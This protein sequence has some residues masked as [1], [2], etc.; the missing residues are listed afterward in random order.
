MTDVTK[1]IDIVGVNRESHLL[2][3]PYH[4]DLEK[5]LE[6]NLIALT[7]CKA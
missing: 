5:K 1:W 6:N 7:F 4:L 3:Q 2:L